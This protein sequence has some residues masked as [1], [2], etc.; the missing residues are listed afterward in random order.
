MYDF[1]ADSDKLQTLATTLEGHAGNVETFINDIYKALNSLESSWND[2]SYATFWNECVGFKSS[3]DAL[4]LIL[5]AYAQI[6]KAETG[7]PSYTELEEAVNA[8]FAA[9][10]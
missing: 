10:G 1:A 9:I 6:L 4:V 7:G 3:L 2:E 5:R 8:A